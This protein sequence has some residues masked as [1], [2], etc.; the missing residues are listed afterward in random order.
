MQ[1]KSALYQNP[2]ELVKSA[3][4]QPMADEGNQ[5]TR[6]LIS[7]CKKCGKT[8]RVTY[9]S[10]LTFWEFSCPACEGRFSIEIVRKRK[11]L[12]YHLDDTH[13]VEKIGFINEKNRFFRS[14]CF[15][16]SHKTILNSSEAGKKQICLQCHHEYII[17][18]GPDPFYETSFNHNG[19]V[20]LYRDSVQEL[21]GY[22]LQKSNAF[23]LDE[24]IIPRGSNQLKELLAEQ[25]H[26][27]NK[28]QGHEKEIL[29]EKSAALAERASMAEQFLTLQRQLE[30]EK[31]TFSRQNYLFHEVQNKIQLLEK[32][33]FALRERLDKTENESCDFLQLKQSNDHLIQQIKQ[34][35][36]QQESRA[37]LLSKFNK[38]VAE[39]GAYKKRFSELVVQTEQL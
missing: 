1:I 37:E 13:I 4:I 8:L 6:H 20:T 36:S 14:T 7:Q 33:N 30:T 2:T 29:E 28:L 27:I 34:L 9:P 3:P 35:E 11:C 26:E 10:F 39:V 12:V 16:C 23:F 21:T 31:I 17:H 18:D 19:R 25:Q 5:I 32:E 24:D 22:I 38:L 15:Y